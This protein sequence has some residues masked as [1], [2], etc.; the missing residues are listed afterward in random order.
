LRKRK[1]AKAQRKNPRVGAETSEGKR[2]S[3]EGTP[4]FNGRFEKFA[5]E[6]KEEKDERLAGILGGKS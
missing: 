3:T 6:H 1:K 2:E 4:G 5:T